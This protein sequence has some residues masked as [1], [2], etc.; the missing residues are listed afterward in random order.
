MKHVLW[1]KNQSKSAETANKPKSV[2][3]AINNRLPRC[4]ST[5][6]GCEG[7]PNDQMFSDT[8]LEETVQNMSSLTKPQLFTKGEGCKK[9]TMPY[10]AIVTSIDKTLT[11]CTHR[12]CDDQQDHTWWRWMFTIIMNHRYIK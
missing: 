1:T 3:I 8:I 4:Q 12:T 9:P 11:K 5:I 6:K 2:Y 10:M 7:L